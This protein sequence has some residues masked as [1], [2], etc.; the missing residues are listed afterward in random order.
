MSTQEL[1]ALER[2]I[3]GLQAR[4]GALNQE[5]TNANRTMAD[6]QVNINRLRNIQASI[7]NQSI[8][9][10]LYRSSPLLR[11]PLTDSS[12]GAQRL[13]QEL[14]MWENRFRTA[15]TRY[16]NLNQTIEAT[17][18]QRRN[19]QARLEQLQNA[20]RVAAAGKGRGGSMG[21]GRGGGRRW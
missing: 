14:T 6:C 10:L 1:Q 11:E 12:P 15:N 13:R 16:D 17:V 18:N 21:G 3:Q 2:T 19:A 7:I 4:I 8:Q 9:G 5:R 20:R